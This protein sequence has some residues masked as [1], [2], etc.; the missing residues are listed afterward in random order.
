MFLNGAADLISGIEGIG[1]DAGLRDDFPPGAVE[2]C[3]EIF[4][5]QLGLFC[6]GLFLSH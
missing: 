2:L 3:D 1:E 4:R 5:G 6:L